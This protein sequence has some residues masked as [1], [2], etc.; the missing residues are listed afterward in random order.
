M[1]EP[2]KWTTLKSELV[3]NHPWYKLRRD[4]VRLPNGQ[5]IDDYFVS[6]RPEVAIVFPVT[7]AKEVIF[8]RQYKHGAGGI[9]LELPGGVFN[10][11]NE[12]AAEAA[13]R[14]L[15]EETG[16]SSDR[17]THLATVFDNPTKDT[18][19]IHMFLAEDVRQVAEQHLDATENIQI[20]KVPL[21]DIPAR[22]A[23]GEI[24][25]A[26]SIAITFLAFEQLKKGGTM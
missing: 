9:F 20:I 25:V 14:E 12:P 17:V 3:F 8:V 1:Q 10:S 4:E 16:Y 18:N 13:M 26:G 6:V 19:R 24:N 2:E 21:A 15:M 11:E 5:I 7:A 23:S 22:I